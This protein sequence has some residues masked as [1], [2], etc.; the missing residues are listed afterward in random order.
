MVIFAFTG[1][2]PNLPNVD[3]GAGSGILSLFCWRA[4]AKRVYAVEAS[5]MAEPL[6]AIVE[7]NKAS[8]VIK[9]RQINFT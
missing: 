5:K 1:H 6:A 8:D 2:H 3:V 7:K 4:G 9:V